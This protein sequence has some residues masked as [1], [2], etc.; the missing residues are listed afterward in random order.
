MTI[1]ELQKE[2]VMTFIRQ[3]RKIEAVKYL[4]DNFGL[5]LKDAKKIT[6]ECWMM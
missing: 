6:D 5:S 4:R 3:G 1:T 2:D